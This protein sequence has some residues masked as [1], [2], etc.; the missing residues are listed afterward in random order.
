MAFIL[1][2]FIRQSKANPRLIAYI[3]FKTFSLLREQGH[4]ASIVQ[5]VTT[6]LPNYTQLSTSTS[7]STN[8]LW[9]LTTLFL[10]A[11][12]LS[13]IRILFHECTTKV[14][15]QINQLSFTFIIFLFIYLVYFFCLSSF[16]F[17]IIFNVR[18]T[19][20]TPFSFWQLLSFTTAHLWLRIHRKYSHKHFLHSKVNL[21]PHSTNSCW[22]RKTM[23]CLKVSHTNQVSGK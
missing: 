15:D 8:S 7:N 18:S 22:S 12:H 9:T 21:S 23:H 10:A 19:Q 5:W 16:Y 11:S 1:G 17:I 13:E 4:Q 2:E 14:C 20:T 6:C 3:L